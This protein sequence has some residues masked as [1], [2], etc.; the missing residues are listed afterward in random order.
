[1][2]SIDYNQWLTHA[3]A[4]YRK[5]SSQ[6]LTQR[7][8]EY[9]VYEWVI[10]GCGANPRNNRVSWISKIFAHISSILASW[11]AP[12]FMTASCYLHDFG[13]WKGGDEERRKECDNKFFEA[14][15]NDIGNGN[16]GFWKSLWYT[17]LAV[18]FYYTVRLGGKEFFNYH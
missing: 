11:I 16:Y 6:E 2:Q 14:I 5:K 18:A 17:I 1:M 8:I 13:Y 3:I 4:E 7:D 12:V 9:L 15:I 10:N